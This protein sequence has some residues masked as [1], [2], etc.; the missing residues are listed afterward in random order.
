[1]TGPYGP[2]PQRG[3][4]PH[5]HQGGHPGPP[6]GQ[7][8]RPGASAPGQPGRPMRPQHHGGPPP[9]SPPRPAESTH[10]S[11]PPIV[12]GPPGRG[13]Q[14]PPPPPR[15]K[16]K[17]PWVFGGAI[18][19]VV[20]GSL[21]VV[22]FVHPGVLVR[23]QLDAN[24]VQHGVR[25]TLEDSYHL[26]TVESVTCPKGQ[27]VVAGRSFDCQVTLEGGTKPVSVTVRDEF[28]TYEVGYPR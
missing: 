10:P 9:Q 4:P 3:R 27:L 13:S 19:V 17:A 5:G 7:Q 22:G 25:Q 16:S 2:S 15:R 23:D 12:V 21:A 24:S 11:L 8:A 14:P 18:L 26:G 1:M 6:V 20:A 28:G